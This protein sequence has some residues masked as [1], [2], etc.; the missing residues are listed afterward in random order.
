MSTNFGY[1]TS[2][3]HK[4]NAYQSRD[5]AMH[6]MGFKGVIKTKQ[7]PQRETFELKEV[8]MP[9][10]EV[11]NAPTHNVWFRGGGH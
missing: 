9:K 8:K 10:M 2:N 4:I 1:N 11:K 6:A 3:P 7:E 5:Q